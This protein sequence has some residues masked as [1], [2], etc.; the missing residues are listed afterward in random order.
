MGERAF[1]SLEEYMTNTEIM[2]VLDALSAEE[3][4]ALNDAID[5]MCDA[6]LFTTPER[7]FDDS[8]GG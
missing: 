6:D 2:T 5:A 3:R 4:I 8:Y 7:L 1:F